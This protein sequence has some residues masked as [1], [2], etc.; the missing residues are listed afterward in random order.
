MFKNLDKTTKSLIIAVIIVSIISLYFIIVSIVFTRKIDVLVENYTQSDYLKAWNIIEEEYCGDTVE[1]TNK[2]FKTLI[3]NDL[4]LSF[5]IY[6][7]K[8]LNSSVKGKSYISVR[9]MIIEKQLKGYEYCLVFAHE[10]MHFK[11]FAKNEKYICIETFKYLYENEDNELHNAG[12]W[13]AREQLLGCYTGEYDIRSF[14][15]NCLVRK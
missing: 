3:E 7:D 15:I 6:C 4:N 14:I 12:V 8:P 9:L 11:K 1:R 10:A 2:E 5:Y 13:Y